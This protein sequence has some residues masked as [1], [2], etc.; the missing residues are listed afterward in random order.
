M[1]NSGIGT[2]ML[3]L[4]L[5][6]PLL[7]VEVQSVRV[8]DASIIIE[9]TKSYDN[10]SFTLELDEY[11]PYD[12]SAPRTSISRTNSNAYSQTVV[13]D[14][15]DGEHDRIYSAFCGRI[16][17]GG[18]ELELCSGQPRFVTQFDLTYGNYDRPFIPGCS[19]KGAAAI[20]DNEQELGLKY[21]IHTV[22]YSRM[23]QAAYLYGGTPPPGFSSSDTMT[24]DGLLY[25]VGGP[26]LDEITSYVRKTSELGYRNYLVLANYVNNDW[27]NMLTHPSCDGTA[28]L[29][30]FNT[31]DFWGTSQFKM[32]TEFLVRRFS[33]PPGDPEYQGTVDGFIVGNE[34]NAHWSWNNMGEVTGDQVVSEYARTL[35]VAYTAIRKYRKHAHVYMPL[36]NDWGAS[37]NPGQPLRWM[38]G[39]TLFDGVRDTLALRGDIEWG[40]AFHPYGEGVQNASPWSDWPPGFSLSSYS[41]SLISPRNMHLIRNYMR[42]S[43]N[44]FEGRQRPLAFTEQGFFTFTTPPTLFEQ[45][46]QAAAIAYTYLKA[47]HLD[48]VEAF[49]YYRAFDSGDLSG[50]VASGGKK[51]SWDVYRHA[52]RIDWRRWFAPY[53]EVIQLNGRSDLLSWE[54]VVAENG[55]PDQEYRLCGDGSVPA[56]T[57]PL[58]AR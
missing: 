14:R 27:W 42:E 48:G 31:N 52:D 46:M 29:C 3:L 32:I 57:A 43:E 45:Q 6:T 23:F 19:R 26:A 56:V 2:G 44:L 17:N 25:F 53:L 18:T 10:S 58:L 7:A 28:G 33:H 30:A 13:I 11:D 16:L 39:K 55:G 4:L 47:A 49:L 35:R 50:L 20:V 15:M 37:Y 8:T 34:I 40:L 5:A 51:L 24:V 36:T 9:L 38:P 12:L 54:D 22:N 21:A 41:T 1:S